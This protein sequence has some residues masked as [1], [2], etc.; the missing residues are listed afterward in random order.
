M[1]NLETWAL[2]DIVTPDPLSRQTVH[3][4]MYKFR[5]T[6]TKPIIAGTLE[7]ATEDGMKSLNPFL[8]EFFATRS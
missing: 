2:W 7:S 6:G 3:R 4:Q 5:W 8:T 1:E